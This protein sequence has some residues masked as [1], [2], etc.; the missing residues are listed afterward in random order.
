LRYLLIFTG[1]F[2]FLSQ[3]IYAASPGIDVHGGYGVLKFEEDE[4]FRGDDF[5]SDFKSRVILLGL[6]GEYSFS[7]NENIYSGI[8]AD[9]AFG[10]KDRETWDRND[11]EV[12]QNDM[13]LSMQFYDLRVGYKNKMDNLYY[14]AYLSGGWDGLRFKRDEFVWQGSPLNNISTEEISLWKAGAGA[15]IGFSHNK[16]SLNGNFMY[17]YYLYGETEDSS[18]SGV[19]FDTDGYRLNIDLGVTRGLTDNLSLY[20]GGNYILQKLEGDTSEDNITWR[21]KMQILAGM[22]NLRYGF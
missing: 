22:V 6:S 17:A 19:K 18:L 16:W 8:N 13:K 15:G 1:L 5:E 3:T 9:W 7:G 21:T 4:D 12:Q 20:L 2:L 14:R 11:I 10:I